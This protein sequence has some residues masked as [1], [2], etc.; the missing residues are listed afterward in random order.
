[1]FKSYEMTYNLGPYKM[2]DNLATY[3][4]DDESD[5]EEKYDIPASW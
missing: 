1:M 4:S 3:Q 2:S 5:G